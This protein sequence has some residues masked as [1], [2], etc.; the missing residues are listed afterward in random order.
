MSKLTFY[1][2]LIFHRPLFA[3]QE[4][5]THLNSNIHASKWISRKFFSNTLLQLSLIIAHFFT[6]NWLLIFSSSY[7]DDG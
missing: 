7:I 5:I 1:R 6:Y 2:L 4:Q 3:A